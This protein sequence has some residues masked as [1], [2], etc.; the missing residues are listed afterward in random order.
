MSRQKTPTRVVP[1]AKRHRAG[2][3]Y[4]A[5]YRASPLE[6]ISMIKHG[7]RAIEAKRIIAKLA[8]GQGHCSQGPETF[9]RYREQEGEA[10]PDPVPGRK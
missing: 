5:V 4:L 2:L 8:I 1:A 9:P 6:R 3:S 7:I 10:R